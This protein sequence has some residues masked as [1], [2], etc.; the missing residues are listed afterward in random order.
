MAHLAPGTRYLAPGSRYQV[1]GAPASPGALSHYYCSAACR[2]GSECLSQSASSQPPPSTCCWHPWQTCRSY[3]DTKFDSISSTCI[4]KT[5]AGLSEKHVPLWLKLFTSC[6]QTFA[7]RQNPPSA[8]LIIYSSSCSQVW[9]QTTLFPPAPLV[10]F[11]HWFGSGIDLKIMNDGLLT[12]ADCE[13][14]YLAVKHCRASFSRAIMEP[15]SR[16]TVCL[17]R[18]KS[19]PANCP[20]T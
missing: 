2:V 17:S 1:P 18:N 20:L 10:F 8:H 13:E 3:T 6:F 11:Y 12:I 4:P 14:L 9:P 19:T 5:L 15:Q 16:S 7:L